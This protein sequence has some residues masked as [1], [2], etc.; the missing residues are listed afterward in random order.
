MSRR[1]E[2]LVLVAL[3]RRVVAVIAVVGCAVAVLLL[4]ASSAVASGLGPARP[5]LLA[6]GLP[7]TLSLSAAPAEVGFGEASTLSGRLT[8]P[9]T[10]AGIS[11]A[12][13]HLESLGADGLWVELALLVTDGGGAVYSAQAPAATTAYR[14]R[15]ADP[16][17]PEASVSN[18]V[19]VTVR[20]LS[21]ALSRAAVRVGHPAF[22]T[23]SLAAPKGSEVRLE[24]RLGG[25]WVRADTAVTK[26]NGTFG[27][28]LTPT[29]AGFWRWR[30]LGGGSVVAL[31]ALDAFRLHRYSVSTRGSIRAD[32]G[33]FR[34]VVAETYADPRGWL[35]G[36]HRFRFVKRGGDFTVVL[37]QA[38]YLPGFSSVCSSMYSCRVGRYVIINQDRWR[39]G[40]PH[41]PGTLEEYRHMVVNH[42]TGHWLGRGHAYCRSRGALAPV[43]QQ[44]SKGMQ[45][46]RVNP[47]PLA[48]EIRAVS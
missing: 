11:G 33:A 14:L 41:F 36:H 44:Q 23:G 38:R 34:S 12:E 30:V 22:V 32:M 35:G 47:W 28:T 3:V 1:G 9:A 16:G 43:M 37:S 42:E 17:A 24:R 25:E 4:P 8:D 48:R 19:T 15:H 29:Y 10:G 6:A 45:G 26:P 27:F 40:S 2:S 7:T 20:V 5:A 46:C 18:E 21:A 39:T 13:V 31:P